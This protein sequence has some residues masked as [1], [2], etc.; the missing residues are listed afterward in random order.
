MS[1]K[2]PDTEIGRVV[3]AANDLA[4]RILD[5]EQSAAEANEKAEQ[6]IEQ[7]EHDPLT[8]LL[9]KP[10]FNKALR[11]KLETSKNG[12]VGILFIDLK[13]FKKANDDFGHDYGD[14]V[15]IKTANILKSTLRS[16]GAHADIISF[17]SDEE[18]KKAGRL[19]GDEFAVIVDLTPREDSE[20]TPVERLSIV[21][22]RI[23]GIFTNDEEIQA[24]GV[25]MSI[26]GA[27]WEGQA[28]DELLKQADAKMYE[29]KR[30]QQAREGSYR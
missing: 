10:G 6:A 18:R 30:D 8:G 4:K 13:D 14:G 1:E 26:G 12:E 28:P 22:E 17:E 20:Y 25:G 5:A 3:K 11:E 2:K 23:R 24:S 9:N 16:E 29:D 19:G 15:L 21:S 7:A 27:V